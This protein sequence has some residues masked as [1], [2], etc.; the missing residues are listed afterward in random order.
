MNLR[1]I[2]LDNYIVQQE[3]LS[4]DEIFKK[5][6][7]NN[8]RKI[9]SKYL[10]DL[11]IETDFV[12]ATG[13]GAACYFN[14]MEFMNKTGLTVYLELDNKSLFNRLKN[15]SKSRSLI[16]NMTDSQLNEFIE[17]KMKERE[18]FYKSAAYTFNALNF[19]AQEIAEIIQA[20]R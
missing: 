3:G 10:K 17:A 6:G 18:V 7:E 12:M 4:I 11:S 9:E 16:N 5:H 2:D 13:G 1:F 15:S 19:D 8:F 14:N 20:N